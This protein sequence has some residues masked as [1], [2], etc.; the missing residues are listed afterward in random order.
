MAKDARPA[1]NEI[2][3]DPIDDSGLLPPGVAAMRRRILDACAKGDIEALRIPI[4][5]NEVKPLFERGARRPPGEDPIDRLKTLS[6]DGK[7]YE[8][9]ATLRAVLRQS[10]VTVKRGPTVL[11]VWPAFAR[12][13]LVEP[14]PEERAIVLTCVRFDDLANHDGAPAPMELGIGADG[15]WHWFWTAHASR[16]RG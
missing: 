13:P 5:W 11:Y 2:V 1:A 6:A 14:S 8:T 10:C 12:R 9:L 15:T 3:S 16:P 4:E 7:G